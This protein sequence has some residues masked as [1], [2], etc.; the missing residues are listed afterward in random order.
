LYP[1]EDAAKKGVAVGRTGFLL[2]M[3]SET[4][5]THGDIFFHL[6][7]VTNDH[8][9]N[10]YGQASVIRFNTTQGETET[11]NLTPAD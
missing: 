8:V 4:H 9:V 11:L 2:G 5:P 1:S 7:A 6:Y 3:G 10:D